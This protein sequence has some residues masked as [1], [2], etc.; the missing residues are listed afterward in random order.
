MEQ[1]MDKEELARHLF[2]TREDSFLVIV[3]MQERLVPAMSQPEKIV[4]NTRRLLALSRTMNLPVVFTE[5]EKL[6]A[7]LPELTEGFT[8][9][10][11]ISK[12]AFN[13]FSSVPFSARIREIGRHTMIVAGIEAHICVTQ[14]AL[15]AHP[16]FNVHVVS[17]A[18][19]SRSPDNFAVAL[20]RMR[21]GG[22]TITSTEMV[23]YELLQKAGTDE[24]RAMLPLIK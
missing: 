2:A 1:Y 10:A 5:Q 8:D 22:L 18:I 19:S 12:L 17:D 15:W 4:A 14:T 16:R 11:P 20:E 21:T 9:F 13:C 23:I 7:T 3:D 24:F 6:G